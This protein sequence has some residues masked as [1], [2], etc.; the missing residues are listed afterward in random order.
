MRNFKDVIK[1]NK[2]EI[3]I[4]TGSAIMLGVGVYCITKSATE[5]IK[6][7][8]VARTL[9]NT[10]A[11]IALDLDVLRN[12]KGEELAAGVDDIFSR[13]QSVGNDLGTLIK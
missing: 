5:T 2:K 6:A 3:F 9:N 10:L 4:F 7:D 1:D 12:M 11:D 13:L 8:K